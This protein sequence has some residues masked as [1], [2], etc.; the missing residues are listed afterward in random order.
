VKSW[1]LSQLDNEDAFCLEIDYIC[2]AQTLELNATI[3]KDTQ[4]LNRSSYRL[5]SEIS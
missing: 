2:S 3:S 1:M 4:S 5:F